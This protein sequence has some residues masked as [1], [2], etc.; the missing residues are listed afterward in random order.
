[1]KVYFCP[2]CKNKGFASIHGNVCTDCANELR[3]PHNIKKAIENGW[4]HEK[5]ISINV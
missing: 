4:L 1:M 2:R 5:A 3:R